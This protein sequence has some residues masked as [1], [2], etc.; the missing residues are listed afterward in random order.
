MVNNACATQALI[1]ILLNRTDVVDVGPELKN[2]KEFTAD[3]D[4]Q[5]RG[6]AISNSESIRAAHN[7]F[8]AQGFISME[9]PNQKEVRTPPAARSACAPV[10]L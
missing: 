10:R 4:T 2:F 1:S 9:D 8:S 7:S 5:L 6:H 3:M